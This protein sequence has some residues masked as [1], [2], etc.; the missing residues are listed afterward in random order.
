MSASD[1]ASDHANILSEARRL[2]LGT[3]IEKILWQARKSLTGMGVADTKDLTE[4]QINALPNLTGQASYPGWIKPIVKLIEA[5]KDGRQ[6]THL[7][8]VLSKLQYNIPLPP[9]F[10]NLP[11]ADFEMATATTE[12]LKLRAEFNREWAAFKAAGFIEDAKGSPTKSL[13]GKPIDDHETPGKSDEVYEKGSAVEILLDPPSKGKEKASS[14][15]A[16]SSAEPRWVP[17]T[18]VDHDKDKA[19]E[20][21]YVCYMTVNYSGKSECRVQRFTK[22]R[23]R[24]VVGAEP[25][26]TFIV[27]PQKGKGQAQP[28]EVSEP[29]DDA[30]ENGYDPENWEPGICIWQMNQCTEKA[31]RLNSSIYNIVAATIINKSHEA[32]TA[33]PARPGSLIQK[34]QGGAGQAPLVSP[35]YFHTPTDRELRG[36]SPDC[37]ACSA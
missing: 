7:A 18:I 22:E 2:R 3:W 13:L 16:A 15:S 25:G 28:G 21:T 8:T 23:V 35:Q 34:K 4:K 27:S 12:T 10:K 20:T 29:Y 37:W 17:S 24:L 11:Q 14:D 9:E 19:G 33:G 36:R 1:E 31:Q 6:L 26:H 5:V 32:A 30:I